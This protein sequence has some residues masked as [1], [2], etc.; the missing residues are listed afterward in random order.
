MKDDILIRPSEEADIA[1][2]KHIWKVCFGDSDIDTN[3]FFDAFFGDKSCVVLRCGGIT[4][5]AAHILHTFE[6]IGESG[7]APLPCPYIYGVGVLPEYRGRGFGADITAAASGLCMEM[8][9]DICVLVP[10]EEELFGFYGNKVGFK[11]F[12]SVNEY[13]YTFPENAAAFDRI[14]KIS[15]HEYN[16]LREKALSHLPHIRLSIN[17]CEYFAETGGELLRLTGSP[18]ALAAVSSEGDT[19]LIKELLCSPGHI[20]SCVKA[21]SGY[22]GTNK[23]VARTPG[24]MKPFGMIKQFRQMRALEIG[25][26]Y[27]GFAFD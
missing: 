21:L 15:P 20:E 17:A 8:G 5:A 23:C 11:S 22:Y 7:A 1:D 4:V 6:F 12:F 9:S 13:S 18:E 27:M 24:N 10:A 26:A 14:Q 25:G 16:T 2:L 19:L 3:R